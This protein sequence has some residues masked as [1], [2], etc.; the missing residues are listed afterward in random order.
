MGSGDAALGLG[1]EPDYAILNGLE[2]GLVGAYPKGSECQFEVR[3]LVTRAVGRPYEDPV[4]GSLNASL[5]QWLIGAGLAPERY[6]ASQGTVLGRAGRVHL[7]RD[8]QG[9]VWVGG[10]SVTGIEGKVWL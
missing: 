7:Q 10:E 8:P 3:A 9:Q 6:T 1:I 2:L 4:T 5:A